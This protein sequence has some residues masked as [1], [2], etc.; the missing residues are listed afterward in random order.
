[1]LQDLDPELYATH[2]LWHNA[3]AV[4]IRCIECELRSIVKDDGVEV[5]VLWID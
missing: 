5:P 3:L 2:L 4:E 1:M